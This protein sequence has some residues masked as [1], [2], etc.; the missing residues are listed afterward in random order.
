MFCYE[1]TFGGPS[2]ARFKH[3]PPVSKDALHRL[4]EALGNPP[5]Q[6]AHLMRLIPT[7]TGA[8]AAAVVTAHS[9][10][11]FPSVNINIELHL[12]ATNDP[13]VY[14]NFF[15]AMKEHLLEESK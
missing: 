15:K 6:L 9:P 2:A 11:G 7:V 4:V 14:N 12:A 10:S 3:Y 1:S 5:R 8:P 13:T